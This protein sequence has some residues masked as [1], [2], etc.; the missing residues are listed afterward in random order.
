M[1]RIRGDFHKVF[2]LEA[3]KFDKRKSAMQAHVHERCRY[4]EH[5]RFTDT[6]LL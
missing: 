3:L 2:G 6:V 5:R 1:R 4:L